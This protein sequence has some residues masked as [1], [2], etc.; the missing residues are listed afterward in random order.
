MPVSFIRK[1]F[2]IPEPEKGEAVVSG[3]RSG[4]LDRQ[5]AKEFLKVSAKNSPERPDETPADTLA[6]LGD[7]IATGAEF[8]GL[9][10]K[11][12][13]ILAQA[14]SLEEFRDRIMDAYADMDASDLGDLMQKAFVLADLS[15]RFDVAER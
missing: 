7:K 15:G 2:N 11:I 13:E 4:V 9:T 1:E 6:A 10:A 5:T 8:D 14:A 12:E 3:Q